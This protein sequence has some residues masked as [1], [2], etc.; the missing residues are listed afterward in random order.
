MAED[1]YQKTYKM[2]AV[3]DEG[4]NIVVT[5]PPEVLEKEARKYG[6]SIQQFVKRFR[7]LAEFNSFEGVH[8]T[9]K[10]MGEA[11]DTPTN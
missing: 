1:T 2:R 5:I 11:W 9:F 10:E 3:G 4:Q 6:L 7:V 8:Y